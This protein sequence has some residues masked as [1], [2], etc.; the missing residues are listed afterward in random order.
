MLIM[1]DGRVYICLGSAQPANNDNIDSILG[2]RILVSFDD[3]SRSQ[4]TMK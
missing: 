2:A 4:N 3:S 1:K